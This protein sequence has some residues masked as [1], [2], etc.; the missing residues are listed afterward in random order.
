[1]IFL[2]IMTAQPFI[3]AGRVFLDRISEKDDN[4]LST[5]STVAV[6]SIIKVE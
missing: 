4:R 3:S 5:T 1:M 6:K 2:S